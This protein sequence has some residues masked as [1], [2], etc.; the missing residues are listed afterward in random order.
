M[1]IAKEL[2][3][4]AKLL[5]AFDIQFVRFGGLSS[6]K[7]KGYNPS[8]PTYHAPPARRG[9]Y[10]FVWPYIDVFLLGK[11]YFD[12]RR[13][14]W[15]KDEQGN[16]KKY[17]DSL[18]WDKEQ[19]MSV[20]KDK[21]M[22]EKWDELQERREKGEKIPKEDFD[23]LE[24]EQYLAENSKPKKFKYEGDIW[25]HLTVPNNAVLQRRGD[26]VKTSFGDYV[27]ALFK[28]VGR[29]E[30]WKKRTGIGFTKDHLEVFIEKV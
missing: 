27:K 11:D 12:P 5:T 28:E 25:H 22:K 9:I 14:K 26:W 30:E 2:I 1:N 4:V 6:V 20:F 17:D 23:K 3:R 29:I 16:K 18:P 21:K 10:A 8:M 7:Q 15:I 13:M 19:G 24:Q